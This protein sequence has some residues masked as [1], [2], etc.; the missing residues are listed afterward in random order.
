MIGYLG[1]EG[2]FTHEALNLYLKKEGTDEIKSL[3]TITDC[4]EEVSSGKVDK[5][6][7]PIENSIEGSVRETLDC[8][9]QSDE[10]YT[11]NSEVIIPIEHCLITKAKSK[12]EIKK[13]LAHR[14]ALRQC[15]SYLKKNLKGVEQEDTT[16]NSAA[17]KLISTIEDSGLA[18]IGSTTAAATYNMPVLE[19][20]VN[21]EEENYTRFVVI[22]N[23]SIPSTGNDKTTIAFGVP[24]DKP[25]TLVSVLNAFAD[26]K[27]NLSR[28]ESRPSRKTFGEYIFYIDLE[29]HKD[30][31]KFSEALQKVS[32]DFSFYR[33]LGSY[34]RFK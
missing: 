8:L 20:G 30:D 21:D 5:C 2:T 23:E 4:I 14:Q 6:I 15:S 7:V 17:V 18:A 31:A 11:I 16:S 34:P 26:M 33:W 19:K 3:V 29:A 32:S 28:I 25:G 10:K 27:I 22:G 9:I 1:P 12:K 13:V 24:Y